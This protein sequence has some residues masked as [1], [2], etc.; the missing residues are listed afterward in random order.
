MSD[1]KR[2]VTAETFCQE[3]SELVNDPKIA[4][5][6]FR[7]SVRMF[8][9]QVIFPRVDEITRVNMDGGELDD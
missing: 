5:K 8:L 2:R 1:P 7:A 4:D 6:G 3:L 9:P